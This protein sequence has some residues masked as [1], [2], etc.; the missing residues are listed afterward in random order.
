M[1]LT[2]MRF[3]VDDEDVPEVFP[4]T[5]PY[6]RGALRLRFSR[7][8]TLLVGENGSGKSTLLEALACA[9][10][11]PTAGAREAGDDPTLSAARRLE[12]HVRLSWSSR[13]RRGLFLRAE[14]YFGFVRRAD[15]MLRE[16]R[17]AVRRIEAEEGRASRRALPHRR[18]IAE[19]TDLYGEGLD[20]RSH[21]ESFLAFFQARLVPGGLYLLDEPEAALSPMRQLAFVSLVK[22]L[23]ADGAQ[24][25]VATHSP[26][27]LACPDAQILHFDAGAVREAAFDELEH[28]RLLRGFLNDPEAYLRH[29]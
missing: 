18:T 16:A 5:L 24:F 15:R 14:D 2:E 1:A 3:E 21:G 22:R 12:P 11:L 9:A 26:V 23:V 8:V 28:V 17:E 7:P 25:V 6:V 27:L 13:R 4:F 10:E 29:L 19:L 20:A